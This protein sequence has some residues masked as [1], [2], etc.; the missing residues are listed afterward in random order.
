MLT[1]LLKPVLIIDCSALC[2]SPSASSWGAL[3]QSRIDRAKAA[4]FDEPAH[5]RLGICVVTGDEHVE[6]LP[7]DLPGDERAGKGGVEC[8]ETFAPAGAVLASSSASEVPGETAGD[9]MVKSTGLVM[10][11]MTLPASWSPY[12]STI[13]AAAL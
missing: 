13:S 4:R 12:R 3:Q 10:S 5:G 7:R 2:S 11:T 8:F 9:M 1:A 6:R